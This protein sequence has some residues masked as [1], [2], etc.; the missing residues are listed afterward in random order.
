MKINFKNII[1]FA[2][3]LIFQFSFAQKKGENIGTEV[4]N[5]VKPYT[6]T[7]SDAFKVKETPVLDDEGNAKKETIKY[8]IFSFPVASTFTPS[9]GKAE[10]VEKEE[11]VHL[12]NNYATF[13]GGNYGVFNGE[14]FVNQDLGANNYVGG[15]F[16]H[17]SSQGGIKNVELDDSFYDTSIDLTYG[18]REKD[19][20]WNLDLGYQNQIYNWYGLPAGFG[21]SLS[22]NDRSNLI[23]GINPQQSY[24]NLYLG[25]KIELEGSIV[26]EASV[27]F[28][29]FSDI[30]GSSENRFYA[31]PS[32]EFDINETAIKTNVVVDYLAGSF[33]KNYWN[34][35]TNTVKYGFT[36]FGIAP[37][38]VMQGEDWTLNI[39]LGLFYSMDLENDNNSFL[40][41]PKI[42]VSYKV[43]G[44]LMIFY[45][46][47]VG[48]LKQ[49]TYSDFVNDNSY[50]SPTLNI[51]PTDKQFDIF[52]GLKGKLAN[53]VSYNLRASYV[54]ERSKAL[55]KSNDYN[56]NNTNEE[57]AF[58]NS[59]QVVYDDTKTVSFYGELKAD[60]SDVVT[61]G[62]NGTFSSYTNEFQGE[63]WNLPAIKLSSTIDFNITD[64]WYAGANVFYVG[65]RKDQK[66]NTD[67]VYITP[68]SPITLDSYFDL[69]AHLGFKYSDRL[70]VFLRANNITNKAYQKWLYYP[71]QGF[72][73]VL[74]VNYKFDF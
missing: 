34:T 13:G 48:D 9:K 29:H 33:E 49:N 23:A 17:L 54:N 27:K 10:G 47:A 40:I 38:Y 70:T 14:L 37:S 32:F 60:I 65:E 58:G 52:A 16:R 69:N 74:G 3:L 42:D 25:S 2:L 36:N 4:V 67:I 8:N 31:K 71:V 50:L 56:E 73:V 72:Q 46:G 26:K 61:F 12:F 66:L 45:A 24:N 18:I 62:V 39:G 51:K 7:I 53:N 11:E 44:D 30:F 5:V 57:Y 6:P 22:A 59:F 1:A 41:Y 19:L 21:S 64:K 15:M 35:N 20:S 68:P 55:F 63:A 28:N 43:V